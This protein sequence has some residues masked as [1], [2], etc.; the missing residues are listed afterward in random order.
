MAAEIDRRFLRL[1]KNMY[2]TFCSETQALH[3]IRHGSAKFVMVKIE[4]SEE[5][6]NQPFSPS[7]HP[8]SLAEIF[9]F[10]RM[11][12]SL[13]RSNDSKKILLSVGKKAHV[14]RKTA[15]LG[16]CHIMIAHNVK[17]EEA[18]QALVRLHESSGSLNSMNLSEIS[19]RSCLSAIHCAIRNDWIDFVEKF[20]SLPFR[21]SSIDM[22][23]YLHYARCSMA[24]I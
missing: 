22:E 7:F 4:E 21:D 5:A 18:Y 11:M 3:L 1:H 8:P 17:C 12:N 19:D 23:E 10:D 16:A 24:R 14:R 20:G 15:F 2:V 9:K 6:E 13:V